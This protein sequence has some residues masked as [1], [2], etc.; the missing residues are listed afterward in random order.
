M[1]GFLVKEISTVQSEKIGSVPLETVMVETTKTKEFL[2]EDRSVQF[3]AFLNPALQRYATV[4]QN[5]ANIDL[6]LKI[7]C[8]LR[9]AMK[10]CLKIS[11]PYRL[12]LSRPRDQST[13]LGAGEIRTG[14]GRPL[15]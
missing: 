9:W 6:R 5:H 12:V 8:Y 7:T 3:K 13:P 4:S 11:W 14:S 2:A 10:G 15:N 1:L